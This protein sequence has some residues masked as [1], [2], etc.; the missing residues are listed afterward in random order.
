MTFSIHWDHLVPRSSLES[1]PV[2]QIIETLIPHSENMSLSELA[3]TKQWGCSPSTAY[4]AYRIN[5]T[6]NSPKRSPD[7]RLFPVDAGGLGG[8]MVWR[9]RATR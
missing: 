5:L 2:S 6:P 9:L 3:K 4:R 8:V 1:A 7:A